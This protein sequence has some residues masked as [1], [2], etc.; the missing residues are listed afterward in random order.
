MLTFLLMFFSFVSPLSLSSNLPTLAVLFLVDLSARSSSNFFWSRAEL[1][2]S[3]SEAWVAAFAA[4]LCKLRSRCD[5]FLSER[6]L[7]SCF[8]DATGSK[9]GSVQIRVLALVLPQ[10]FIEPSMSEIRTGTVGHF[11]N[12][13]LLL[14]LVLSLVTPSRDPF[15][16]VLVV[17]HPVLLLLRRD[18][19]GLRERLPLGHRRRFRQRLLSRES[20]RD[21]GQVCDHSL[22][23]DAGRLVPDLVDQELNAVSCVTDQDLLLVLPARRT[24]SV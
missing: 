1:L 10:R 21:R 5:S 11:V 3:F 24:V 22:V 14:V 13:L 15:L 8:A 17:H 16:L 9:L 18:T 2:F 23:D 20:G 6:A 7:R 19:L 12:P 4:A